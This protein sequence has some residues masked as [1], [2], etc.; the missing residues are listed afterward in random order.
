MFPCSVQTH[1]DIHQ[2]A[3][4]NENRETVTY[5]MHVSDV[6]SGCCMEK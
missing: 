4:L 5:K 6:A 2:S 3:A 1:Y